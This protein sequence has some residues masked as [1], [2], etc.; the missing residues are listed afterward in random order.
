MAVGM[1]SRFKKLFTVIL[2]LLSATS[3]YAQDTAV[4]KRHHNKISIEYGD[5]T[6]EPVETKKIN[7]N[8]TLYIVKSGEVGTTVMVTIYRGIIWNEAEQKLVGMYPYKYVVGEDAPYQIDQ[9]IWKI[10][11]KS[12]TIED[13]NID[14]N[15]TID[16]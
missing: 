9:P 11:D 16:L 15:L 14:L 2:L 12:I 6:V 1:M 7:A 4:V 3:A 13:S 8:V 5:Q 10:G